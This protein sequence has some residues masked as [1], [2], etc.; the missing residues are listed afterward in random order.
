[1]LVLRRRI[2]RWADQNNILPECQNGFRAGRRSDENLFILERMCE[3]CEARERECL[4]GFID[5]EKAYDRVSREKMLDVLERRGVSEGII[6]VLR[7][8][9]QPNQVR[10]VM[11]ELE[12]D[13]M[14]VTCGVRQ[15]CPLS[16]L[17]FNVYMA[18]VG[19]AIEEAS[20]GMPVLVEDGA[21]VVLNGMMYAD[22]IC[23]VSNSGE[24]V[25]QILNNMNPVMEEYGL[26]VNERKSAVVRIGG[27]RRD[28]SWNIGEVRI[29]EKSETKYLGLKVAGGKEGGVRAFEGRK[30][31]GGRAIGLVKFASK[32]SG[33]P[34]LVG[35]EAWKGGVVSRWMYGCGALVWKAEEREELERGQREFGRWLWRVERSV[36]NE[37]VHGESGWSTYKEREEKALLDFVR[38]VYVGGG[39]TA[40]VGR[41]VLFELGLKSRWWNKI[42]RVAL[43]YD[44]M[45]LYYMIKYKRVSPLGERMARVPHR[46]IEELGSTE[47][48][49]KIQ[50]RARERWR[51]GLQANERTRQYGDEKRVLKMEGYADG[52]YGARVRMMVRGD[53]LLVRASQNLAWKYE[54]DER[55]CVCGVGL[56]EERHVLLECHLYDDLRE[57]WVEMWRREKGEMDLMEGVRGFVAVSPE[58]EKTILKS[59]GGIWHRRERHE[60]ERERG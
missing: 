49:R 11:E 60:R 27:E 33:C 57:E 52:S 4:V 25:Q 48:T 58:L 26:K 23:I 20:G 5:L 42:N 7:R 1:M 3:L 43:E 46:W 50:E 39:L 35:R 54:E 36:R 41:G 14:E 10:L 37:C 28:E 15:G 2:Q 53:S 8:V 40:L 51:N 21:P 38:R 18:E 55:S 31:R 56:E 22:D 12:T 59:V 19:K 6:R 44:F 13:W 47:V 30:E 29:E 45:G 34:F 32:R 9:Y 16:P 17:L 24:G